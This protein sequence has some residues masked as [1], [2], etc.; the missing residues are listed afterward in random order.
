MYGWTITFS[1]V[2]R[3]KTSLAI[4]YMCLEVYCYKRNMLIPILYYF[5]AQV[6]IGNVSPPP[7]LTCSQ[8]LSIL[9]PLSPA[10]PRPFPTPGCRPTINGWRSGSTRLTSKLDSTGCRKSHLWA[11]PA[12]TEELFT[13]TSAGVSTGRSGLVWFVNRCH[14][15]AHP[16]RTQL[17]CLWQRSL[18]GVPWHAGHYQ[19]D[20]QQ[21]CVAS[22]SHGLEGVV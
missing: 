10:L 14:P 21:V 5:V 6:F 8:L 7:P 13:S 3:H 9:I 1:N 22:F 16:T 2:N 11:A 15:A 12:V 18:F 19:A 4:I 17:S 20:Q